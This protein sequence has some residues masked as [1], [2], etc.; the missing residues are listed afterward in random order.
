MKEDDSMK[1][2]HDLANWGHWRY[3]SFRIKEKP[4][5]RISKTGNVSQFFELNVQN[6]CFLKSK[7][8]VYFEK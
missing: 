6:A 7:Y 1:S 2:R 4:M 5:Y 8:A 3:Y